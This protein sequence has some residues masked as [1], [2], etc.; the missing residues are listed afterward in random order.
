[1]H[2]TIIPCAQLKD[3]RQQRQRTDWLDWFWSTAWLDWFSSYIFPSLLNKF[4]SPAVSSLSWLSDW[5]TVQIVDEWIADHRFPFERHAPTDHKRYCWCV[6]YIFFIVSL[7]G[8]VVAFVYVRTHVT[9]A[10]HY[11]YKNKPITTHSTN[12]IFFE[13]DKVSRTPQVT[14][15]TLS[16]CHHTREAKPTD[17]IREAPM[18]SARSRVQ[19]LVDST[20][21]SA[22]ATG[23]FRNVFT[24]LST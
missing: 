7:L 14:D 19:T 1:V 11:L 6:H 21:P 8:T 20:T 12:G 5:T 24:I 22:Q 2:V 10:H 13:I 15:V 23:Y 3:K 16:L 18:Q 9:H 17:K 4:M